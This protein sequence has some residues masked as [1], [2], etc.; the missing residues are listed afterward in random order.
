MVH[1][2]ERAVAARD[3]GLRRISVVTRWV[4]VA[5]VGL[6]GA[7]ALLASHAFHGHA[8]AN[9]SSTAAAASA[10]SAAAASQSATTQSSGLQPASQTPA[11]TTATPTVVSGGS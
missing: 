10:A 1:R 5:V 8:I 2:S 6:S 7:L 11:A 9:A 4:T 3:A